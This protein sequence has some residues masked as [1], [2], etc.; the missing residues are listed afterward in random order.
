MWGSIDIDVGGSS[1][2]LGSPISSLGTPKT[3]TAYGLGI[4]GEES[5][6]VTDSSTP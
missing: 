4:V 1:H 5:L 2:L 6:S 3:L